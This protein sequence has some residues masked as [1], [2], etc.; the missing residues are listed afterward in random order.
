[1]R[2]ED[3]ARWLRRYGEAWEKRDATAA[4]VLFT[5]DAEY[6]WIPFGAPKRGRGEIEAAWAGATAEQRDV[7]FT[8]RILATPGNL[9]IANW[10]TEL[11]R[12][13]TSRAVTLDGM[14]T[15]EFDDSRRCRVFREWW[16]S[17]EPA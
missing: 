3:F 9:G 6:Y 12:P 5:E 15:A 7:R 14:L 10:H 2:K 4:G 11:I 1:M 17:T 16:H 13:V 8:Y